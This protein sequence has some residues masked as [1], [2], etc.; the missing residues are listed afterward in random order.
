MH[1]SLS[2][3][4][5]PPPTTTL[6]HNV[7]DLEYVRSLWPG[8]LVVKGIMDP[9]DA[10]LCVQRGVDALVVSNHGGRQLDGAR[11]AGGVTY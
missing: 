7:R 6:P 4:L 2:C 11:Y 5:N 3:A 9:E 10:R 8:K 1:I